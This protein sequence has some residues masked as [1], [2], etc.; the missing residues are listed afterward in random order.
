MREDFEAAE[1][2]T[3]LVSLSESGD[4]PV[5]VIES[6]I[7]A[8]LAAAT[9]RAWPCPARIVFITAPRAVRIDR[10]AQG[11]GLDIRQATRIVDAK[12]RRKQVCDQWAHCDGSLTTGST[13]MATSRPSA[14]A[15][16]GCSPLPRRL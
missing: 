15:W 14:P 9:V 10:L 6:F 11:R 4:P 3:K 16:I 7:D 8:A 1:F 12:D 2:V 5:L 13:M